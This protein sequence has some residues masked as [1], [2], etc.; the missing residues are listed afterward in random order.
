MLTRRPRFIHASIYG[1]YDDIQMLI[2]RVIG[3]NIVQCN[4]TGSLHVIM[5]YNNFTYQLM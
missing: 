2:G 4:H 5:Q 1:W 3:T